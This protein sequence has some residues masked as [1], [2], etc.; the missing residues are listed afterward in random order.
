MTPLRFLG[1]RF[2]LGVCGSIAAY[3]AA[4][5]VRALVKEGAEVSVVMTESATR[6]VT[7]LTFET[8]TKRP[9]HTDLFSSRQ[10]M[11][12]LS[13]PEQADAVIIAPATANVLAKCAVGLADDLLSTLI[14]NSKGPLIFAPAMDGDMWGHPTVQTNVAALRQRSA[15]V[16]EP[17]EGPLAS[18][19]IGKGRLPEESVILAAVEAEL[20]PRRDWA[21]ERVL[22]SAGPTQE[23]IDPVRYISN[24]SSGRMGYA[25]AQAARERGAEVA[26]VSGPTSLPAPVGVDT[27]WVGSA[28]EMYKALTRRLSSATVVIMAA[29][30]ADFRPR[31]PATRKLKKNRMPWNKL[32]LEPTED[33]L[34]QLSKMR[35]SQILVG[36]AAET[37]DVRAGAQEKLE[38]KGLD[39]IV[40]NTVGV[41][42]S[43]FGADTNAAIVLDRRG[44][45]TELDLMPKR[46]LADCILDTVLAFAKQT[47]GSGPF[48]DKRRR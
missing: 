25:L 41:P 27:E 40:G 11:L 8:L 20:C 12:H 45:V 38:R 29:A 3:K 35:T 26:L 1:K 22:I 5:L 17:E 46:R 48:S 34:V 42:G 32:E 13:L 23:S 43:G 30:V 9:V 6:F 28:E 31:R 21:G 16:L 15:I 39:L 4:G 14:L 7:P 37:H 2:V 44:Q 33:I 24:R 18:G 19:A 10:E 36:F 47:R